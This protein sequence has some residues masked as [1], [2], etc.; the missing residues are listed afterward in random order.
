MYGS[1]NGFVDVRG[2]LYQIP[3]VDDA[4]AF[5]SLILWWILEASLCMYIES[6]L[7]VERS[8][9]HCWIFVAGRF[10]CRRYPFAS[11][12]QL[13]KMAAVDLWALS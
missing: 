5:S 13:E 9:Q 1:P 10:L 7:Q 11:L 2:N 12:A 6:K 8:T 4:K 3:H